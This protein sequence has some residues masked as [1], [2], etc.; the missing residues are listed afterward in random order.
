MRK[1]SYESHG[2]T[3]RGEKPPPEYE[4]WKAMRKRCYSPSCKD[5]R[6]YGARGIAVCDR[7]QWSFANFIEDM[8]PRPS[9]QYTIERVKNNEGYGPDNCIWALR[10]VQYKNTRRLKQVTLNG[11]AIS[12]KDLAAKTGLPYSTVTHRLNYSGDTPE[13]LMR[14]K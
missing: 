9:D 3:S 11:E 5:Y 2:Y 4:V 1:R 12:L 10:E 13:S 6:Y 8:G 7:W 14:G